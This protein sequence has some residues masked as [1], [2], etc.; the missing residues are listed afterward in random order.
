MNLGNLKFMGLCVFMGLMMWGLA[1]I[2]PVLR[3]LN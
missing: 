1:I 2:W 3:A